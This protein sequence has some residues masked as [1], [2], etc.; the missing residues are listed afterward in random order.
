MRP[1][2]RFG[3]Y[4]PHRADTPS[5][6]INF[7]PRW[8][9]EG[10]RKSGS[11]LLSRRS[12]RFH[13]AATGS[14]LAFVVVS[15]VGLV[16]NM[17]S[18]EQSG[19]SSREAAP[20]RILEKLPDYL[21]QEAP[22][23]WKGENG[24]WEFRLQRK[25]SRIDF[26]AR[27]TVSGRSEEHTLQVESACDISPI[28]LITQLISR[29]GGAG[30]ADSIY[31]GDIIARLPLLRTTY[32]LAAKSLQISPSPKAA[33]AMRYLREASQL[34]HDIELRLSYPFELW[35]YGISDE[36]PIWIGYRLPDALS[37]F[38]PTVA[39]T[40]RGDTLL[41]L[42]ES[43]I[44]FEATSDCCGESDGHPFSDSELSELEVMARA[45]RAGRSAI[46]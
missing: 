6:K 15:S 20:L 19:W 44:G 7:V 33:G 35:S 17:Y 3:A 25:A 45:V 10:L 14:V 24:D 18:S 11:R 9:G 41:S 29:L 46:S 34:E 38:A 12:D 4:H 27:E 36:R 37:E 42:S 39:M 23:V 2:A 31:I 30:V 16:E 13:A 28:N 26:S 22:N 43:V 21:D 5:S 1:K 40:Y 32:A 8:R